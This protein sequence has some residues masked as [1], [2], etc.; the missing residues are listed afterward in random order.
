MVIGRVIFLLSIAASFSY[1]VS[2]TSFD[3][4]YLAEKDVLGI[5]SFNAQVNKKSVES[6]LLAYCLNKRTL[7]KSLDSLYGDYLDERT[8]IDLDN[9]FT[10]KVEDYDSCNYV[11]EPKS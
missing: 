7:P 11:L 1:F 3:R 6:A 8:K 5:S 10:Y 9:L 4:F 2:P